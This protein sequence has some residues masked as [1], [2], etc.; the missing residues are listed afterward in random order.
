[1][2][3]LKFNQYERLKL[4]VP[5]VYNSLLLSEQKLGVE[6]VTRHYTDV[7]LVLNQKRIDD[8]MIARISGEHF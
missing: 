7:D 3:N 1:M 4:F 6:V 8:S 5:P 2:K